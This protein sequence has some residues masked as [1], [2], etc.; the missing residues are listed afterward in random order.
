MKV[1]WI[2][3]AL[4]LLDDD[5]IGEVEHLRARKKSVSMKWISWAAMAACMCIV[6]G[7]LFTGVLQLKSSDQGNAV[8]EGIQDN[9]AY[10]ELEPN[11]ENASI[12]ESETIKDK[13][14][15][16]EAKEVPSILV[17]IDNWQEDGFV[18]II[19]GNLDTNIYRVGTEVYVDVE[20]GLALADRTNDSYPE[21]SVVRVQ[22]YER[23]ENDRIILYAQELE[24]IETE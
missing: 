5:L 19:V 16:E 20:I 23:E 8:T 13:M 1:D 2:H 11:E 22:F 21:G 10:G 4:N 18:G 15:Q 7:S 17:K 6:M 9:Q 24:L 12:P 14:E 3:E